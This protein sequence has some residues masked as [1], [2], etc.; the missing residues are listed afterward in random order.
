MRIKMTSSVKKGFRNMRKMLSLALSLSLWLGL[1]SVA[2]SQ[3]VAYTSKGCDFSVIFPNSPSIRP[4]TAQSGQ[5][6]EQALYVGVDFFLRAECALSTNKVDRVEAMAVIRRFAENQGLNDSEFRYVKGLTPLAIYGRGTKVI[7][8][9]P[10]T[11]EFQCEFGKNSFICLSGGVAAEK[12]PH[13]VI[14]TFISSATLRKT[15]AGTRWTFLQKE[16]S[17]IDL[18]IGADSLFREGDL[19]R[20]DFLANLPSP[21]SAPLGNA[22]S[23]IQTIEFNCGSN[24]LRVLKAR[25]F[26]DSNGLGENVGDM[27]GSGWRD[28][29]SAKLFSLMFGRVCGR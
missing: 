24:S 10:T 5:V 27:A 4:V 11:Y 29:G 7:A 18:F 28:A 14:G 19:M 15:P 23:M 3:G 22:N 26:A 13:R 9:R 12:S 25:L 6:F 21:K 1:C 20:V 2:F 16:A 17:G 8:D